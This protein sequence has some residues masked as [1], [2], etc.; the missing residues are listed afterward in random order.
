MQWLYQ[1]KKRYGFGVL[2]S[3]AK[4]GHSTTSW[5]QAIA[6]GIGIGILSDEQLITKIKKFKV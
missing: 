4:D 3:L 6:L 2:L 1:S 5:H